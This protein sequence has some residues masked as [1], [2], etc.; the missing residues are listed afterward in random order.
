LNA[1]NTP[2]MPKL[3]RATFQTYPGLPILC[4][5]ADGG[6]VGTELEGRVGAGLEG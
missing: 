2:A 3:I 4:A 6:A 5:G 1:K